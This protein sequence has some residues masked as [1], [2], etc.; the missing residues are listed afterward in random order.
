M[1]KTTFTI[2]NTS[3]VQVI[4]NMGFDIKGKVALIT[5]GASGIGFEYAKALL[6]EE[7]KVLFFFTAFL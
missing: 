5:G 6:R 1:C 2:Q 3:I 4:N 7:A